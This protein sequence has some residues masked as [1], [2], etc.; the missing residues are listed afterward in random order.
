MS[1]NNNECIICLTD[2]S[3]NELL[4]LDCCKQIV[5]KNCLSKWIQTN[6]NNNNIDNKCFHCKNYNQY[7]HNLNNNL[8]IKN[9][10]II[11]NNN[12]FIEIRIIEDI[13]NNSNNNTNTNINNERTQTKTCKKILH[14]ILC[15]CCCC[16]TIPMLYFLIY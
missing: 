3:I 5:H 1:N 4:L 10:N 12:E 16:F 13:N 11:E 6:I 15:C 7:I 9:N 2:V 14:E 8:S